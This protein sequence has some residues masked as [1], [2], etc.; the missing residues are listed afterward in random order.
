M[1]LLE[2]VFGVD[3]LV[4]AEARLSVSRDPDGKGEVSSLLK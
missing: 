4:L 1:Q 3:D 2:E